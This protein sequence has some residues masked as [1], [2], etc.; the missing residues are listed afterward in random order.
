MNIKTF[1]SIT[2]AVLCI[3]GCS[4]AISEI[5]PDN[6]GKITVT[7][8]VGG[9]TK[10]GYE[11]TVSLPEKFIMDIN[12]GGDAEYDYSLLEMIRMN[13]GNTYNASVNLWWADSDHSNVE[14]KAIT[15][16]YGTPEEYLMFDGCS[17]QSLHSAASQAHTSG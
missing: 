6:G 16:P 10:A 1:I 3:A 4:E 17:S 2:S 13:N 11:G 14:V 15:L 9:Q 12:Q 8:E 5:E 7:T